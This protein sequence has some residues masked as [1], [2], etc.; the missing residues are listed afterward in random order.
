MTSEKWINIAEVKP[1]NL[2]KYIKIMKDKGYCIIGAEQT[3]NG[4]NITNIEFPKKS[5]LLLG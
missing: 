4:K 1:W 3:A 5:L 2:M